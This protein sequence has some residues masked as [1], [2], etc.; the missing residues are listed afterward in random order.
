MKLVLPREHGAWGML[1]GPLLAGM[2]AGGFR[3]ADILLI[4]SM[5][6]VYLASNPLIQWLKQPARKADMKKW[7]FGYSAAAAL[8]GIPLV[9]ID[10]QLLWLALPAGVSLL[11]NIRFALRKQERHLLND[12]AA[13]AGLCLG[14]VA[15][16]YVGQRTFAIQSWYMWGAFVLQFFGSAL[17][18]K[19]LIREKGNRDVKMAA[20]QFQGLLLFISIVIGMVLPGHFPVVYLSLAFAF[21]LVKVWVTPFDLNLRP[22]TVGLIEIGNTIW[23]TLIVGFIFR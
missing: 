10:P 8:L 2:I 20:N 3:L 18:V 22:L 15:A 7:A 23:F 12:L 5:L 21:S 16:F 17:Y 13:I 4:L 6:M 9:I 14:A 19:T 1:F 11:I